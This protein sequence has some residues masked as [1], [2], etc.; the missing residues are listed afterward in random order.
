[1]NVGGVFFRRLR[2]RIR[3]QRKVLDLVFDWTVIVYI[4][5]PALIIIAMMYRSTFITLPLWMDVLPVQFIL[6]IAY[7]TVWLG[8]VRLFVEEA[9]QLFLLQK[10][11]AYEA[12][13]RYGLRF[14]S[15]LAFFG[16]T[17][18][19]VVFLPFFVSRHFTMPQLIALFVLI[20]A[21]KTLLMLFRHF[22]SLIIVHK[23]I[24]IIGLLVL[25][26][27]GIPLFIQS[28]LYLVTN[29]VSLYVTVG[30][31]LVLA[32]LLYRYIAKE[33]RHFEEDIVRE[34]EVKF[35]IASMLLMQAGVGEKRL[36]KPRRRPWLFR[37]SNPIFSRRNPKN[38]MFETYVKAWL[39]KVESVRYYFQFVGIG[40]VAIIIFPALWAPIMSLIIMLLFYQ[41][42]RAEWT[43]FEQSAF[44]RLLVRDQLDHYESAQASL[45]FISFPGFLIFSFVAGFRVYGLVGAL[46]AMLFITSYCFL[47]WQRYKK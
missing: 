34:Q 15:L 16:A 19:I 23:W 4:L 44:Y 28:T 24:R 29:L 41:M 46:V 14:S 9:D 30:L 5:L 1:M 10:Q 8:S 20:A 42:N 13:K 17:I 32:Y 22:C 2:D 39:R 45:L 38:A 3:F 7:I 37:S 35:R 47:S 18:P 21:L 36:L 12:L 11:S 26:F 33:H 25:F 40:I 6:F 31:F 43:V 27:I